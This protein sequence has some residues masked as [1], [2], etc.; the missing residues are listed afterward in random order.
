V[1][2][3]INRNLSFREKEC[4]KKLYSCG[5]TIENL[6][7]KLQVNRTTI[8]RALNSVFQKDELID[9]KY[10]SKNGLISGM[11]QEEFENLNKI[12]IREHSK[13]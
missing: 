2:V 8:H 7:K 11:S 4:I 1:K 5:M 13:K 12:L 6:S 10:K 9:I 3:R